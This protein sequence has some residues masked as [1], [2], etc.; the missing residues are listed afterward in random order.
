MIG[1]IDKG[2]NDMEDLPTGALQT[3]QRRI[4]LFACEVSN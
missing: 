2:L 4:L 3:W 1:D